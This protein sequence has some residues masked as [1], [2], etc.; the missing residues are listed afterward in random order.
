M[1]TSILSLYKGQCFG[2]G[3]PHYVTFDGT[4]YGFQGNCS[5]WLMREI[6][7]TY[8]LSVVLENYYC[9]PLNALSCPRSI[10]IFYQ[11]YT[12]YLTQEVIPGS[13]T[14]MVITLNPTI[15]VF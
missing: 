12:I 3:D 4:Y 8:N 5:Y 13:F 6:H 2:W 7:P 10:T 1:S 9:D 14:N 15:A 11:Q